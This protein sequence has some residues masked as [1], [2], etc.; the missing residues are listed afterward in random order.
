M[1]TVRN[2]DVNLYYETMG[3]GPPVVMSY[4]IGGNG[5][6]WWEDFP[7]RL[8][9]HCRLVILDNRG[10]G[11]S[12]K[13]ETPWTMEDV[14]SDFNAVIQ[15]VGRDSFHLLGCSLEGA[16]HNFWQHDPEPSAAAV[17]DFLNQPEAV[18]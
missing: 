9:E 10:T 15:E 12:D 14:V 16:G 1:P 7:A 4:G 18:R 8:A 17:L 5:R 6:Q 11:F 13:P 2:G 3:G